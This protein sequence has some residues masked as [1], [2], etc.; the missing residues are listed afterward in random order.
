MKK[1]KN[2]NIK[3]KIN[4]KYKKFLN[5]NASNKYDMHSDMNYS[6][7]S[8][9]QT[10]PLGKFSK[11]FTNNFD[12]GFSYLQTDKWKP[13]EYDNTVCKIEK[14]VTIVKKI[15]KDIPLMLANGTIQEKILPRDNINVKY[16]EDKLN[17]GNI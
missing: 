9:S 3:Q 15:M 10:E 7:Y 4:K 11:D 17:T 5:V 16:I 14:N 13:P 12:H 1:I 8:E 6:I 2:Q